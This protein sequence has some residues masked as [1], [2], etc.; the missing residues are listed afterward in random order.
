MVKLNAKVRHA[1]A[2]FADG[3]TMHGFRELKDASNTVFKVLWM[4]ALCTAIVLLVY[5]T[6]S[7]LNSYWAETTAVGI[8]SIFIAENTSF[9]VVYCSDNWIDQQ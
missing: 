3:S 9:T 1:V 6:T 2:D 5:Q 4:I 7:L 8:D